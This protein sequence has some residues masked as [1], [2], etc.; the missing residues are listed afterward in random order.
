MRDIYIFFFRFDISS[1]LVKLLFPF[2][3]DTNIIFLFIF[4][5]FVI[6]KFI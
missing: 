3:K 6:K 2:I 1:I 5:S 4:I